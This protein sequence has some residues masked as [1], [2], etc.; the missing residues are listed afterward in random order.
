MQSFWQDLQFSARMLLKQPGFTVIAIVTLALG[1]GANTA[2]FSVVNAMLLRPLPY[3]AAE[4]LM[5]M[6][7]NGLNGPDG[8]TG[9]T[10]FVDWRERSQSFEQLSIVRSW[11]GTL[12]GQGEPEVIAGLRVSANYFKLL[13]VAPALGRDFRAEE[14]RPTTR[15]VIMLSH[16]LWQRRFGS[17]P[18]IIGKQLTLSGTTF[19]VAGVMPAGFEDY[20][21]ANWYK[22]AQAWAPLGYDVSQSWACRSCQ[23]LKAVARLKADVSL[24]QA[25]VEMNAISAALQR[26]H[27]KIY[28]TPTA[29]VTPLQA[30]FVKKVRPALYL[31][32]V[33]VG[34]LL[35]IACVN[36][37]NLLLARA[38]RRERELAIRAALGAGRWR[39]ARQLLTESLL[40][41][42]LGA[43]GGLLLA[44]WGTELLVALSPANFPKTEAIN[45]DARVLGFTLLVSLLTG[46]LFGSAPAWQAARLDLQTAL[47]DGGRALTGGHARLR[48]VLVVAEVALALVLLL[49]AGLLVRSFARVLSVSPG[50]ETGNLVTMSIPAAS[51]RYADQ[52]AVSAFYQQLLPRV[53]ALPGVTAAGIVSNL[54]L[55]GNMD[56]SG[57]H[58]EEK[59]LANP[60]EAPSAER[61]SISTAYLQAMGIPL[62]RGRAFNERDT[63]T[64]PLVALVNQVTAKRIWPNEDPLGKRIRL[65]SPDS[66]LRAIVG[67]VGDVNHYGLDQ[68]P[69]MQA[70]V[71]H[72]QWSDSFMQLVVRTA[73]EPSAVVNAIRREVQALDKE[74][75]I[76][77][78]ATMHELVSATVAPRRFILTLVG[79]FA[80]LALLLAAVGIYGVVSYGVTQRTQ[81]I[82]IRVALGAQSRDVL[83][84]VIGQGMKLALLG[85]TLGVLG[86]AGLTQWMRGLLFGIDATDPLTFGLTAV[87]LAGVALLACWLPARRAATVDPLVALRYE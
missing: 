45:A 9:Y 38:T 26:E 34:L 63:V 84:L 35:L 15:F 36:V 55:G 57:F 71:P 80:A 33:A 87:L 3:P 7:G 13:G 10:T 48:G 27:P 28:V 17:D 56:K 51:A 66:P 81:E 53:E 70:Y 11:G 54:P 21:S 75:P 47:K 31:L 23:H 44:L 58:V 16:A 14:D 60:A 46:L 43:A 73:S 40:L 69:D 85:V 20:L 72:A 68:A 39:I 1:I 19:T 29:T 8:N 64:A 5:T 12:T 30:E 74:L 59:P 78:V 61:Y 22:P 37:A 77:Q 32:L 79:V 2:I 42:V 49:G 18:N 67:I 86:A 4:R 52:A 25:R 65:G 82:G 62:L 41:S 83:R 76:N 6:S 50:F 24:A